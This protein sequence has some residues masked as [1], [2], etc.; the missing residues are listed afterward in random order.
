MRQIKIARN[1]HFV[2]VITVVHLVIPALRDKK[3]IETTV[4][5]H[6]NAHQGAV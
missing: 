6:M 3:L 4:I 1:I 2:A 5:T